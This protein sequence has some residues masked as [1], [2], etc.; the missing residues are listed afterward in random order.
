MRKLRSG[1][2]ALRSWLRRRRDGTA[3]RDAVFAAGYPLFDINALVKHGMAEYDGLE[4]VLT[5]KGRR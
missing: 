4:V 3:P 5:D 1:A 2:G